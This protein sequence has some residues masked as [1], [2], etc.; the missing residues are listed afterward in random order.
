MKALIDNQTLRKQSRVSSWG[1]LTFL[2]LD[3]V[4]VFLVV[5]IALA[6][7]WGRRTWG[8]SW[9]WTV[10]VWMPCGIVIGCLQH[11]IGLMGHEASHNLLVK[12]RVLNDV[13]AELFCFFPMF[14]SIVQYRTKHLAHHL[15]PNDPDKDPNL[16][17]GK[18]RRLYAKFPMPK[19]EFIYQYYLKFFWPPFVLANLMDLIDVISIGSG[20]GSVPDKPAKSGKSRRFASLLGVVYLL[21]LVAALRTSETIGFPVVYTLGMCWVGA[22]LVWL[23]LPEGAFFQ[24]ARLNFPIK[25]GGLMR[26]SYN[27]LLLGALGLFHQK[28]GIDPT[29]AFL[30]LWIFPLIY[31]FPYLMLLREVFQHANAGRGKLDNSRII[32]TDCFTRWALLG[33][34]NDFHLIH[35]LYPNVPQYNLRCLHRQISD[36]SEEYRQSV[37]EDHGIHRSS[38]GRHLAVLDALAASSPEEA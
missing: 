3:W 36:E 33:Y 37:E 8:I 29:L 22:F 25:I 4:C 15:Y 2:L 11:R 19:G 17:N 20:L 10:S 28:T 1:N 21:V 13:L 18:A 32:F 26:F 30:M 31:V 16:G 23:I 9:L 38:D 12:N 27:T 6:F 24:G 35:H 5:A 14:A 34:G 7:E